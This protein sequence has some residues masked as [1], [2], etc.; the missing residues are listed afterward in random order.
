MSKVA[1]IYWS[2]SGNTQMMADAIKA[3]AEGAGAEVSIF[4]VSQ[5]NVQDALAFDKIAFGCPAMGAEVLEEMEFEPFFEEIEGKLAGKK[6]ALFGS[7]DWGDGEWMRNWYERT[8]KAGANLLGDEG[9]I[10]Q[11]APDDSGIEKCREFG[12]KLANY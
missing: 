7:Y 1:I 12:A 8:D 4:E 11:N 6:V 9:L 2:Q 10:V 3:G 5:I